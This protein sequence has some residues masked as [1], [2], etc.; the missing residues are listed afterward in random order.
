MTTPLLLAALLMA[1]P[2]T[3]AKSAPPAPAAEPAKAAAAPAAKGDAP[4]DFAE[5]VKLLFQVVTC[6]DGKLPENLD[7]KVVEAYCKQQKPHLERFK[8]HWGTTAVKFLTGLHPDD[9]P[10]E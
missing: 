3:G 1:A 6:Q 10:G 2:D 4:A 5:D 7:A 8:E 9:L